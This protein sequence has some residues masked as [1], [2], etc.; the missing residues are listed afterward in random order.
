M[1]LL[2]FFASWFWLEMAGTFNRVSRLSNCAASFCLMM[3]A[4]TG[5]EYKEEVPRADR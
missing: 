5:A 1:R 3:C 2:A 4:R